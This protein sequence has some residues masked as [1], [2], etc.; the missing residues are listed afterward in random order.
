M[1]NSYD[2]R[3]FHCMLRQGFI[4]VVA[5]TDYQ[6]LRRLKNAPAAE[7]APGDEGRV[8]RV[9]FSERFD[10]NHLNDFGIV[11]DWGKRRSVYIDG[12]IKELSFKRYEATPDHSRQLALF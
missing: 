10:L 9:A 6:S 7:I 1:L 12:I 4:P 3:E 8:V 5:S 2:A 11:V